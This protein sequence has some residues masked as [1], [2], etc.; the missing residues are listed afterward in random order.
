MLSEYVTLI[1]PVWQEFGIELNMLYLKIKKRQLR[2]M[3][4]WNQVVRMGNNVPTA[5][6]ELQCASHYTT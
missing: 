1:N 6:I 5:G 2:V 4:P 3:E